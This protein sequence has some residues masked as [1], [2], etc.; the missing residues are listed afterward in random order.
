MWTQRRE[1]E[2]APYLSG[3]APDRADRLV[4]DGWDV[5]VFA[6]LDGHHA[7]YAPASSDLAAV[8]VL[9]DAIAAIRCPDIEL[10]DVGERLRNYVTDSGDLRY[11]TGSTLLHTDLNPANVLVHG[12]RARIV[13]WGWATRGA[14]WLDAGYWVIALIASGHGPESAEQWAGKVSTWSA[15]PPAGVDAFAAAQ[16]AVWAEI[17]GRAS[18]DPWIGR[19]VAAA[20]R[21]A[22]FRRS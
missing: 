19:M 2:I 20:D 1:T 14:S 22:A 12:G 5:V 17:G 21:W 3:V 18:D 11:L 6:A 10:R 7:D 15:A 4:A 16:A 13:D 9:L 8:A